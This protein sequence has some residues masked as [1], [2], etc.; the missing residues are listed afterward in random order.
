MSKGRESWILLREGKLILHTENADYHFVRHG[1]EADEREI[2]R[3][4]VE[5]DYPGSLAEVDEVLAGRKKET[6]LVWTA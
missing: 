2:T 6:G 4:E 1:P 3:E 5:R